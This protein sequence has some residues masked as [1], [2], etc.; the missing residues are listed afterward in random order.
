MSEDQGISRR[1]FIEVSLALGGVALSGP[2]QSL[3]S[4]PVGIPTPEQVQG[5]FYPVVKPFDQD[6]DLTVIQGKPGRAQGKVIHVMGR[7][8]NLKSKPVSGA[9]VEIWQAN[10]FGRYT[11]PSDPNP[12]PLDPNFEGYGVQTTDAEGRYRF[13]TIKP[14]A[15]PVSEGW[16]RPPHIHFIVTGRSYRLITQMYFE[17]D[18]LNEKDLILKNTSHKAS[19]MTKLIPPTKD[20]EPDALVAIWDIVLQEM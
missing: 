16:I 9:Q 18:P 3:F 2:Y 17:G 10:T 12:A 14:G 20:V 6:A 8:L 11:H 19:L 7:V 5:P 13:K 1:R 4:Q 15:Y